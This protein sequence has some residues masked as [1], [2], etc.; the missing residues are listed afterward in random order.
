MRY[1]EDVDDLAQEIYGENLSSVAHFLGERVT[2]VS[3][4]SY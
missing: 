4:F 3:I 2:T 1:S